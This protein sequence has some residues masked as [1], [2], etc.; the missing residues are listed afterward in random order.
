VIVIVCP[1]IPITKNDLFQ[2]GQVVEEILSQY[3]TIPGF[4]AFTSAVRHSIFVILRF[5]F[6]AT[7]TRYL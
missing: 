5:A 6:L 2:A 1:A 7:P 4:P 3:L